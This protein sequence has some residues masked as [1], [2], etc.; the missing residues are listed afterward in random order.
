MH[1]RIVYPAIVGDSSLP[2]LQS[3]P[4]VLQFFNG[5]QGGEFGRGVSVGDVSSFFDL[6]RL[7]KDFNAPAPP[8][9]P[10]GA[11]E[12]KTISIGLAVRPLPLPLCS[13]Y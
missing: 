11:A 3:A 9:A 1:S 2:S 7:V 13:S 4:L 12:S 6:Q 8:I 10:T 5:T